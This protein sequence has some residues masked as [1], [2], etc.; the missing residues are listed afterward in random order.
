M[1]REAE[2]KAY[3][4]TLETALART[5]DYKAQM[6]AVYQYSICITID[7][8]IKAIMKTLEGNIQWQKKNKK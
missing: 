7:E 3:I 1:A 5:I 8:H 6:A 2:T 4:K